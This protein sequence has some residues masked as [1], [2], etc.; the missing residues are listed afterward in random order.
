MTMFGS[1]STSADSW[2]N[3]HGKYGT[4]GRCIK[5]LNASTHKD[6]NNGFPPVKQRKMGRRL[7]TGSS[8]LKLAMPSSSSHGSSKSRSKDSKSSRVCSGKELMK[9]RGSCGG[10]AAALESPMRHSASSCGST[11]SMS[12]SSSSEDS[13]VGMRLSLGASECDVAT[14][15]HGRRR[16]PR[17]SKSNAD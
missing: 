2:D 5:L 17:R 7:S 6:H 12:S 4:D 10:G 14:N 16:R 9:R 1:S 11:S 13:P 3:F 8:I 15:E